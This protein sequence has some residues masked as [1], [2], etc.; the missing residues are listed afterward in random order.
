MRAFCTLLL[1]LIL[2]VTSVTSAVAR[3]EQGALTQ[4]VVCSMGA[5]RVVMVDAAGEPV[6]VRH[7]CPDCLAALTPP[8]QAALVLPAVPAVVSTLQVVGKSVAPPVRAPLSVLARGPPV[9]L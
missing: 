1:A 7:H 9:A 3:A 5:E 2:A 4:M 6:E 8:P